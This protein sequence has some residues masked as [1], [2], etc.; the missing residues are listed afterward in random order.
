[1][2]QTP[3]SINFGNIVQVK[4]CYTVVNMDVF[5]ENKNIALYTS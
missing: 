2:I 3:L 1:M 4:C 5:N